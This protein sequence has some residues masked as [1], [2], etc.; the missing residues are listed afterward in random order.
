M[1]NQ[2]I[3]QINVLNDHI[4]HLITQTPNTSD[5]KQQ[6]ENIIEELDGVEVN[7]M[8][9]DWVFFSFYLP[10]TFTSIDIYMT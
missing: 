1:F 8:K 2:Y 6:R 4:N 3:K 9:N 7:I 10:Y 5:C